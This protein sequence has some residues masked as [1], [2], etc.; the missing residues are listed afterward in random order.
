MRTLVTGGA[1]FIGSN[2]VDRLLVEGHEVDVVD[3]FST[4]SLSNLA[5]AR[6]SAGPG[7]HHPPSGHQRARRRRADGAAPA[8]ARLPSGGAGRRPCVGRPTGFRRHRQHRRLAQRLGGGAPGRGRA[9]RLRRQRRHSLRRA[10]RRGPPR[11]RVAPAA[12]A[13]ALRRVQE[14]R[15][16]L[17]R[18]LPGAA[19]PRIL[20]PG[21]RR[22]S[23]GPGRTLMAKPASSPSS[24]IAP[25]AGTL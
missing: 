12:A 6:G 22:T 3:D 24:P 17:P 7:A 20:R 10:G 13:V 11:A 23:T 1:G 25:C 15:H 21:P 8:R 19:L 18:G 14:G 2:L 9:R 4:G 16:R 5:E